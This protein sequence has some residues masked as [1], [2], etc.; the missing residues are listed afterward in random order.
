M[1]ENLYVVH[2]NF[3]TKPC[4]HFFLSLPV[5][6][7]VFFM[8]KW[9]WKRQCCWNC[10]VYSPRPILMFFLCRLSVALTVNPHIHYM[11][12]LKHRYCRCRPQCP[13]WDTMTVLLLSFT[14]VAMETIAFFMQHPK[15]IL[16]IVM[17]FKK[18]VERN[19]K[20]VLY[21]MIHNSL[22]WRVHPC[23]RCGGHSFIKAFSN[24]GG[25]RK[26]LGRFH[27]DLGFVG[28]CV[29]QEMGL[30]GVNELDLL[31]YWFYHFR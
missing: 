21:D 12:E 5:S 2:K 11:K 28:T 23:I 16:Q 14:N 24:I 29:K 6:A 3:Y 17:D 15:V 7:P 30:T 22:K 26:R 10:C 25:V 4:I 13:I 27:G 19:F 20:F 1:N 8:C 9:S 31:T 18:P